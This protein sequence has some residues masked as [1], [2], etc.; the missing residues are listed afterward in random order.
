MQPITG[1]NHVMKQGQATVQHQQGQVILLDFWATWCP[2]CQKPMQH[3][4]DMLERRRDWGDRVRLIGLSIDQ[5][6]DTVYNHVV[7]KKWTLVEHYQVNT[8]GCQAQQEWGVK[9]VPTVVLVDREGLVVY[10]GHPA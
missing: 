6:P 5:D 8:A 4:Q 7:K 2:P 3:N 9:G 10:K 1:C